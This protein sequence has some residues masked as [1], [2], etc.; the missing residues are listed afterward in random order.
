M[1]AMEVSPGERYHTI[2]SLL[3]LQHQLQT[4]AFD[5]CGKNDNYEAFATK[6]N[7]NDL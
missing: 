5:L 1:L 6:F 7:L 4:E 2:C 3:P